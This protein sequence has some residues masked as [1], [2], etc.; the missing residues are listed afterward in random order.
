MSSDDSQFYHKSGQN[1]DDKYLI[2][3]PEI[4]SDHIQMFKTMADI[5][6]KIRAGA[7]A[8]ELSDLLIEL[9]EE[10]EDHFQKEEA[11]MEAGNYPDIEEHKAAHKD[12]TDTIEHYL[13]NPQLET[14][15]GIAASL[16][17]FLQNWLVDHIRNMDIKLKSNN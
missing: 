13:S 3:I 15:A 14:D 9:Y 12:I 2:N 8:P 7:S 10:T 16:I 4:D 17:A 11:I 6:K 5:N 1:W